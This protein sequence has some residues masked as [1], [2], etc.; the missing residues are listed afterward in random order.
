MTETQVRIV[1][2][3]SSH[4]TRVARIFAHELQVPYGFVSV[5]DLMSL[6][7]AD[8][9][10]NPAL[11][12]PSL[13][14]SAGTWFGAVNVCRELARRSTLPA[15]I[16]WPEQLVSSLSSN[17]LELTLQA[18]TTEVGI[19]MGQLGG[20]SESAYHR[21]LRASLEGTL[22][23]L[24]TNLTRVVAELAHDRQLSYLEVTLF[25]LVTHLKFRSLWPSAGYEQL[26]RFCSAFEARPAAA[27]TSYHFQS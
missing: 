18:M 24:D 1:G 6:D 14:T 13:E 16:V 11:K 27:A 9:A 7:P 12:L 17:A 25:C 5:P 22:R 4:F 26:E 3:T 15:A 20:D 10:G 23:W 19:I 21:K 8:Y 2:R